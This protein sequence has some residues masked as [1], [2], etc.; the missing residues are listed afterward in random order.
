MKFEKKFQGVYSGHGVHI[1]YNTLK[2]LNDFAFIFFS[3]HKLGFI[4]FLPVL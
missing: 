3:P 1:T 4:Y 2:H